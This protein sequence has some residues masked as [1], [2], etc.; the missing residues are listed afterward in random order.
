M[1]KVKMLR[2]QVCS[3]LIAVYDSTMRTSICSSK[4]SRLEDTVTRRTRSLSACAGVHAR[5]R[6]GIEREH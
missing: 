1:R 4:G 2:E 5:Q 3:T 6:L